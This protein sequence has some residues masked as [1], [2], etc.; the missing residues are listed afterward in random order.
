MGVIIEM[1]CAHCPRLQKEAEAMPTIKGHHT[2][3][4]ANTE[5]R[6]TGR[7]TTGRELGISREEGGRP[8]ILYTTGASIIF[9]E[10]RLDTVLTSL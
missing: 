8:L 4:S 9:N 5:H 10:I 1:G 6:G 2:T 7:I 3:N